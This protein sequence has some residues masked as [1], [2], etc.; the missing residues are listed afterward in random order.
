MDNIKIIRDLRSI[1][2]SGQ[3]SQCDYETICKAIIALGGNP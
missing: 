2:N 1:L 3:L